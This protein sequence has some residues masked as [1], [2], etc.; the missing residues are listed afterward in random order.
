MSVYCKEAAEMLRR[1]RLFVT[2]V[3]GMVS[4]VCAGCRGSGD[5]FSNQ[6]T[7]ATSTTL[8]AGDTIKLSFPGA[9]ELSQSQKIRTDGKLNL[10]LVG[11]VTASGKT[12]A[13]LQA[14][15]TKLYKPQ[16]RNSNVVVTLE[17]GNATVI[18]SGFVNK[19]GKFAFDRP[20]SV[21]Q[22]IMEAGGVNQYGNLRNIHLVRTVN[23]QQHTEVI[24][25][26][27][28]LRGQSVEAHY[29]RDGDVIYVLQKV[30]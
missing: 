16:L 21:F 28:A 7:A 5:S 6:A 8:S 27:P 22:A 30:F 11:E 29:V 9:N 4:L 3:A 20:T 10:P 2:V 14:E 26:R 1:L 25:L 13:E 24:D 15:L 19:P 23:G 12:I 17:S 18:V